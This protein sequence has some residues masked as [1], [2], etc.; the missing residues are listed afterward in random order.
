MP[1]R[2]LETRKS[3]RIGL[4]VDPDDIPNRNSASLPITYQ[5][6]KLDV[7]YC[8]ASRSSEIFTAIKEPFTA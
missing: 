4:A 3:I 2:L 7:K 5:A 1:R 6:R 8:L